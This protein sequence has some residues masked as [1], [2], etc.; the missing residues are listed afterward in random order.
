M[1][2]PIAVNVSTKTAQL[3]S[4]RS[5]PGISTLLLLNTDTINTVMVGSDLTSLVVPIAPNGS[6]SVDPTSNWYV[7]GLV[8]GNAPLVVVPNGQSNFLGLTQGLG[9]LVIPSIKSPNFVHNVSGWSIN[10]DGSA[11]FHSLLIPPGSGGNVVFVQGTTPTAINVNDL[12]VDTA[13]ANSIFSWNGTAWVQYQFGT[14]AIQAGSITAALIAA[15]TITAAQLAAGIIYAGIINGTTVNAATFTGSTFQGTD[16]IINTSGA[17]FYSGTP[18]AGNLIAS[19]APVAGTDGF[20]NAYKAGVTSYVTSGG[21]KYAVNLNQVSSGILALPGLSINDVASPANQ[22]PGFFAEGSDSVTPQALAFITSGQQTN[23]DA[24]ASIQVASQAQSGVTAG[25]V[26]AIAG[27][28]LLG[29]STANSSAAVADT[30]HGSLILPQQVATP[31]NPGNGIAL[32]SDTNGFAD[33]LATNDL[34]AYKFGH[35]LWTNTT[36]VPI[37]TTGSTTLIAATVGVGTYWIKGQILYTGG[38]AAGT[39]KFLFGGTAT[40]GHARGKIMA[41]NGAPMIYDGALGQFNG[42]TLNT[43]EFIIDFDIWLP[44]SA[45]GTFDVFAGENNAGDN[46]T[47][48]STSLLIMPV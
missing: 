3:W 26:S 2:S 28:V 22:P 40:Q 29:A 4:G 14:G 43:V 6:L 37:T 17:F 27:N 36:A 18:A 8:T 44:F 30:N 34:Q 32:Y 11:E 12:W 31:P 46:F 25:Q 5:T 47:V 48:N 39:P 9:Q 42:P 24:F 38:V 16:F 20:G 15:N 35:K 21:T 23:T 33:V 13:N 41:N 7:V 1:P 19:V 10:K 45:G